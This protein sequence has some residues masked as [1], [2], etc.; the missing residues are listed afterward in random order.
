VSTL[1]KSLHIPSFWAR[2]STALPRKVQY[3]QDGRTRSFCH[4]ARSVTDS[5]KRNCFWERGFALVH[6]DRV[7]ANL[8]CFRWATT[9][10]P[11]RENHS[12]DLETLLWPRYR[13]CEFFHCCSK[14]YIWHISR[15][16]DCRTRQSCEQPKH[17]TT[18]FQLTP[19]RPPRQQHI[20]LSFILTTV[21]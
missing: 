19:F 6:F 21:F 11:N 4:Q 12:S 17:K 1:S 16:D 7:I 10:G 13:T 9:V 3:E 8:H 5:S 18:S 20:W 14:N 2:A 15:R